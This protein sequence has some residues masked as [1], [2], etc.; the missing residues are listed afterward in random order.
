MH[1]RAGKRRGSSNLVRLMS[2]SRIKRADAV[3]NL[4]RSQTLPSTSGFRSLQSFQGSNSLY[5]C[6]CGCAQLSV[7]FTFGAFAASLDH[8]NFHTAP[9]WTAASAQH[10]VPAFQAVALLS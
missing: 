10:G 3:N 7:R 1:A 2:S 6:A 9:S 4:A 5:K 8:L